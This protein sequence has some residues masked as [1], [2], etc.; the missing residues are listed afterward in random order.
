MS[1]ALRWSNHKHPVPRLTVLMSW[2]Y[3]RMQS[4]QM[5]RLGSGSPNQLKIECHPSGDWNPWWELNT[6]CVCIDLTAKS[7][8]TTSPILICLNHNFRKKKRVVFCL[9]ETSLSQVFTKKGHQKFR[10]TS[11]TNRP[12]KSLENLERSVSD[13]SLVKSQ[14]KRLTKHHCGKKKTCT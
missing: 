10:I 12:Q 6:N 5:S 11:S 1:W 4:W 14:Q 13:T 7:T 3:W 9:K 2:I 8:T